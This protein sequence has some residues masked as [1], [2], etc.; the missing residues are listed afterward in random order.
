MLEDPTAAA[1]DTSASSDSEPE[2]QGFNDV[3][4]AP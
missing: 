2:D 1:S 4:K 3:R